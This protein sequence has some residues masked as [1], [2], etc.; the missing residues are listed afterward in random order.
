[1][2]GTNTIDWS[3][4]PLVQRDPEKLGGAPNINGMRIGP[5]AIVDNFEAGLSIQE[6]V[7]QFPGVS[8]DEVRTILAYAEA[9]GAL[10]QPA[11]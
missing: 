11:A 9:Q 1:M 7:E 5:E 2:G 4:C 6:I 3:A 10:S 8:A